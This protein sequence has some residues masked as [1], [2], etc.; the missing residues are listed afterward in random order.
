[1]I[2]EPR[3]IVFLYFFTI[4]TENIWFLFWFTTTDNSICDS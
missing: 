2:H 3:T 1:M 4:E